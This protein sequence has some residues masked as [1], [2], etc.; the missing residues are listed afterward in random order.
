[1]R[2]LTLAVLS[3][4]GIVSIAMLLPAADAPP[5]P[6]QR[7]KYQ[8][9]F[10]AGN[11]KDAYEGFRKLAL[12]PKADKRQLTS[13]FTLAVSCLQQL[14]R[15]D[16]IDAFR[17]A[18]I[19][20]HKDNW[21]L[22]ETAA[23][24]YA[25]G[26][27]YGFIIAGKFERGGHRG[28]GKQVNSLARDRGRALQLMQQA[29]P[30]AL[31]DDDK[32]A[33]ARFHLSFANL[34][35]AGA[36]YREAWRLQYLTDLAQLPD[37]E[38]GQFW[39]R[40][41]DDRAAP[42]DENG[43]PVFH[44]QTKSYAQAQSDG[45]RWRWMLTQ[46]AEFDRT[47]LNDTHLIFA[48]F[49]REQFGVETLARFGFWGGGREDDDL[50]KDESGT[51][52]LHTLGEDETIARLATGIKRFK[53]PDEFNYLK[54][55]QQ[56]AGRGKSSQGEQA[57]NTLCQIFEDRRQYPKAA[58]YWRRAIQEYGPGPNN[59]RQE[60]L[61]Q[62]V[63][64]WGRFENSQTQP[65]GAGATVAYR[66]R[67]GRRVSFEAWEIDVEKLLTDVKAYLKSSPNQL[68]W[69]KLNIGDIGYR[70]VQVNQ[71]QYVRGRVA[72]WD[73]DL[74]PRPNHVDDRVT[75]ATPL[76]RAGAYLVTAKI[77]G[78]NVAR[79]I[80]WVADTVIVKKPLAGQSYYYVADAVTGRPVAKANVEFF[81]YQQVQVQPNRNVYKIVT[82]NFSEFTDENGQIV[83][84]QKRQSPN[85][86]WVA[87]ARTDSGRLAYLGFSH[88]WYGQYYDAQ[89]NE[90][91]VFTITDRPVY[92]PEQSVKFK[93][94]VGHAK[95]DQPD[96][97]E[98][99]RQ[100]FTV[101]INNPQGEK[102]FEK[103]FTSDE[104][105]GLDG[106]YPLPKAC[107]LGLYSVFI[108]NRGGGSFRVEEYKK[109]EF[110]VKVEA[111]T[112][113]VSLGE[114]I[115]ATIQAKYYFGAPVVNAKVK[116]K[117]L[118]SEHSAHWHPPA[119]WDWF[120]GRGYWWFAYDYGWYPGW[121]DWG[122]MRPIAWWWGRPQQPPELVSENEVAIGPDG[123][124]KVEIDTLPA[125]ELHGDVDHQY[126]ITA[127]VVDESRRTIVG[128]GNVLVARKPFK[129]FAW[130]DRGHYRVGDDIQARFHAHTLDQKPVAGKGELV[131]Y[132][133][134]Y[135]ANQQPVEAPIEKWNLD[136]NEQGEARQQIKAGQSGQY[137]LS[138][139][140]TDEKGRTIEGGYVFVVRGDDF[141]GREFRFND[142]E[143]VTDKKEYAP[144][145]TIRLLINTNRAG[146]AVVLFVRPTNG[147][148]LPPKV[149]LLAGKSTV[150]EIG[151]VQKDM[152][153]FFIEA[154]TIANGKLHSELREVIVPPEKRVLNVAVLP[155]QEEYKPGE[156]ATLKVKLTDFA[157]KPFVGS[158][159]LSVYDKSV[160]YI[161]G[162]S[163]VPEIREFFWKWRRHHHPQRESTLD[164][165]FVNLLRPGEAPMGNLGIFGES[166]IDEMQ[167]KDDGNLRG[168]VGG[169]ARRK[170]MGARG[171]APGA[172]RA[173]GGEAAAA[174]PMSEAL[175]DSRDEVAFAKE[176]QA[177][178]GEAP[179]AA[180]T[181]RSLFADTAY[182]AAAILTDR[183]GN[184][185]IA[186]NMPENLTGWKVKA[187]SLGAGTR[188][189]QGEAEVVTKKNLLVRL[190]APRF[191]VETDEVVLSANVHNYLKSAKSVKVVLEL[192][193]GALAPLG[194]TSTSVTIDAGG[195]QRVD[196]RVKVIRD[197][198]PPSQGAS[199]TSPPLQG[200]AGGVARTSAADEGA[201]GVAIVRMKA[202]TD[203]ESDA[204]EMKFPVFVH[205][206]S[207]M[208]SFAGVIRPEKDTGKVTL[209]VPAERRIND[210]RL[211]LRYSPTLAGAMV[212]ALPYMVDYP[213]G[214]TEQTLNRFL[215]TVIT[216]NILL[217]MNLNLKDIR[218]K[219]TNLN[220]QEIGD[221]RERAKG[222]KRYQRNPV[223]DEEEVRG[224]VKEGLQALTAMQ[225]AD[226]G[227]G[228]FSG[229]GEQS[230][231]HTTAL[232]VHG[233]QVARSNDVALVPGVI[234]RG[235]EWLKVYQT[236]QV[237]LL[238]N[239]AD[240]KAHKEWKD[241]ADNLDAFVYMVLVD[242]D[243]ADND[244]LEFLYRDRTKLAVYG[245]ALYGLALHKQQ[246]ADK[247]AMILTNIEQFLVQD[248]ENQTAYLKLPEGSSW[249]Y[250]YGS[251]T[252]ANA[253]Y[254]KLLAKT[255]PKDEK[256]S[257][258][259][260][261]LLN[262]RKHAT[263]WNST[264][265]TAIAIEALAE[266]LVAS[267]EGKP[268]MTLEVWLDGKKQKE[269]KIDS[270][271]LFTFD[272]QFVLFGD[273][274]ETG[275]HTLELRKKGAGPVYY[276]AYLTNFTLEDFITRAGLEVKVNRKYYRLKKV[277]K[278][279]KVSGARGQALDQKVEKYERE[280]LAN[281]ATLKS[282]DLVEIELEIDSKN[283]Y[284]YLIF[285][286][287]KASG[288]EPQEVR[289]GYGGDGLGAY[290]ELRD[291]KV[292]FFVRWLARGK[293]S[294]AYRMRAEIPGRF[295]ALP[296]R[297]YAMYAPELKGNSDEIKLSIVD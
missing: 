144:G 143:L 36:G 197:S 135:D 224:M 288:F 7:P 29:L 30:L 168:G 14:G 225:L 60:R 278:S 273:A 94:W 57:L 217:R 15:V 68:D 98:F 162:G 255:A 86:Q 269:V 297:A 152:P 104:F 259:V 3:T 41:A 266:Y 101:Q 77:D 212:D 231:P 124:I 180:P 215:P 159:V 227:W 73:L 90:T 201:G 134:T 6:A 148:Y 251:E 213:Y 282:G 233:L 167:A 179:L 5:D 280:E 52:A 263:Y 249:W 54:L 194:N 291:E 210:S 69:D 40:G 262:N 198:S 206:M 89:Y 114:K 34:L 97:S 75:V 243:V 28:G 62:I 147:I 226:G 71:N 119:P 46:A 172:G 218:E 279:V 32:P 271:N 188:V 61:Q 286:D 18:V 88:V 195:E 292:C 239:A 19:E 2:S 58:D 246:Q 294:V 208:E 21:R 1:M 174:A 205:G 79:S 173:A 53:L 22:L 149:V 235:V 184:A 76:Q 103:A 295:S 264:R 202:L 118:R 189:G 84:D 187:W 275:Q 117:V 196:W 12:D 37:Y 48:N 91:K 139:K 245:K 70:L 276:N 158:T 106:E 126:S 13:D 116:Y 44:D 42:V 105:G 142:L 261:Y 166:V 156:K 285:E 100:S 211:E 146:G 51:Y 254:L 175:A 204:M 281:L 199:A 20:T 223:F 56:I 82:E 74:K 256:A 31:K 107:P 253:Y 293:H 138:Y 92:R 59:S 121:R 207:K 151:V 16:E 141:T 163:N 85:H 209:N 153:N 258:L 55:Y 80:V 289:S 65:A 216:Q 170:S 186:L 9:A 290:M 252:E 115:T 99:A 66:F 102:V 270:S 248:D 43:N 241:S 161:S 228:W 78:G 10:N 177:G 203:E 237:Q 132:R 192:E 27:H 176:G 157:G 145:D 219:R 155:S 244:M 183:E 83:L 171:P 110:E 182:W 267:G 26:E 39:W 260:K 131:L 120:Y 190:Q 25:H 125:K 4:A 109:P 11:Y 137:R 268:D 234:E 63:G 108:V 221:D 24:S 220:A 296:T 129:V 191:F 93:F 150:E 165:W 200:G 236:R 38:E 287:M 274:V 136:T 160:E 232:V 72:S 247:L 230:W 164:R 214:C 181:L 127:E 23:N 250:W 229:F 112:E 87:I 169:M 133:V 123:T 45:Q 8:Q 64:N 283:D 193:G 96:K 178:E 257:R 222:W 113:P 265:D 284:E 185:E 47:L 240:K 130:V 50:K 277:D 238:K 81:G 95:Y 140:L 242:A 49:L 35:L 122:C 128:Q 154:F 111:P 67:N 33:V 17:E 272:N